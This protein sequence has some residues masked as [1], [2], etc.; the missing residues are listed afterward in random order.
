M[1]ELAR[2]LGVTEKTITGVVDRLERAELVRRVR[3]E[4]DRRVIQV[5]LTGEGSAQFAS[6]DA[7][8]VERT[9]IFLELLEP[10]DREALFRMIERLISK[11]L[12][13]EA[14]RAVLCPETP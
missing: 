3:N 2:R 5:E 6:L 7:S 10:E 9:A 14:A 13:P 8:F 11:L 4:A 1:G 12:P